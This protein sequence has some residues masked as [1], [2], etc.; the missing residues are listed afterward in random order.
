MKNNLLTIALF[1]TLLHSTYSQCD[2]PPSPSQANAVFVTNV[3]ELNAAL[4]QAN[5]QNGNLTIVLEPGTYALSSNLR[6]IATH[7]ENLTIMGSTGNRDDVII[8]GLG[9]NN[10]SV[11]HIFSV[12]ADN[13]TVADL[14]IGEVFYHAIQIHSNPNDADNFVMQNVRVYDVKEQLIKVSGGGDLFADNGKVSCCLFEFTAGIGYQ[15]YTGGI[16]AHRSVNW[17]VKNNIFKHIRSP[18]ANLAEHAIHFWRESSGTIVDGNQIIDCDRGIGFGLGGDPLGGHVGGL[19]MNNFVHTSRDVGIGL[20]SAPDVK[21]YNNTVI[22]D[23][24]NNSIE[25]RFP[26]TT[27]ADIINNIVNAAITDRSSGS[28]GSL[29][30]NYTTSSMDIFV[31]ANNYDY[32]IE[33]MPTDII[34]MGTTLSDV[35][36]DYDCGSRPSGSA[37]D[38]GADEAAISSDTDVILGLQEITLYPNPTAGIFS[39][40]GELDDYIIEILDGS[41][42]IF[43]TINQPSGTVEIDLSSL[44]NGLY[45]VKIAHINTGFLQMQKIITF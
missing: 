13:F 23:N 44:P 34:D 42:N 43:D 40:K 14:T 15:W 17:E 7:M 29:L 26:T 3:S 36:H 35:I 19:I 37:A 45:F 2:C 33:G 41:G 38:I 6:F 31:D 8:K 16:D 28:T 5:N 12:A 11:T 30:T 4:D 21:I 25:Y 24:Y 1:F 32:H 9:W 22:T 27:N 10:N 20:E 39:I 18:E